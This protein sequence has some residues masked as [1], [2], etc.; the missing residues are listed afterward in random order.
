[1][2]DEIIEKQKAQNIF[3]PAGQKKILYSDIVPLV[4]FLFTF[5]LASS[6]FVLA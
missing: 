4:S 5:C 3:P 2:R 6:Q 1:M